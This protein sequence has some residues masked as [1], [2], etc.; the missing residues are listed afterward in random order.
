MQYHST[1]QAK[2][3]S[4][5][6]YTYRLRNVMPF[7]FSVIC[8]AKR[9]VV[10]YGHDDYDFQPGM[11]V[12]DVW[13]TF[14]KDGKVDGGRV[15]AVSQVEQMHASRCYTA[16]QGRLGCISC[17]DPHKVPKEEEYPEFYRAK[18]QTC[19]TTGQDPLC[20]LP[21]E[22]A[23]RVNAGNNCIACHMPSLAATDVPHTAQTDHR[24]LKI[25]SDASA[26]KNSME[27]EPFRMPVIFEEEG[28]QIPEHE[29]IRAQF[30]L[31][32][33][34]V[35]SAP[36][37][38]MAKKALA[39]LGDIVPVAAD[40]ADLFEATG[41]IYERLRNTRMA[42]A[43]W[44]K[45]L[46]IRGGDDEAILELLA[47]MYHNKGDVQRARD[48]YAKLVAVNDSRPTYFGRFAHAL[49][50]SGQLEEGIAVAKKTV[51]LNPGLPQVHF[52]LAEAYL[53]L[54]NSAEARYHRMKAEELV[55]L[56]TKPSESQPKSP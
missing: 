38:S 23:D 6:P 13:V 40:D 29:R 33:E 4:S 55:R 25:K 34:N 35:D 2:I 41:L 1:K 56:R 3:S 28:Y 19:H 11:N 47:T 49:G 26:E 17:H 32:A 45:A 30:I 27:P 36:D 46:E 15:E 8:R 54:G 10:R 43:H 7:A 53:T 20:S 18:C 5:T 12:N 51:S 50:Q 16:S 48:Y 52:W 9:R 31:I 39:M 24:V 22:S 44:K 14:V 42:E 21:E 37:D